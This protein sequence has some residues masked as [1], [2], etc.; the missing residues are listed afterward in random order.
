VTKCAA[1]PASCAMEILRPISAR[2]ATLGGRTRGRDVNCLHREITASWG[3]P[4]TE[5]EHVGHRPIKPREGDPTV[6]GGRQLFDSATSFDYDRAARLT[7]RSSARMQGSRRRD[8]AKWMIPA[9]WSKAWVG[10][11]TSCTAPSGGDCPDGAVARYG[12]IQDLDE[13]SLPLTAVGSS[14]ASSP[15]SAPEVTRDGLQLV[16]LAPGVTLEE[17][18]GKTDPDFGFA[19]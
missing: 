2:A 14:S 15:T 7:L 19:R 1:A 5:E 4:Y 17:G 3:G 12:N 16:E 8:I 13:C 6:A 11:R 10:A 9:R 18:Q